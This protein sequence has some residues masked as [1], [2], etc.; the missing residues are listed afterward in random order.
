MSNRGSERGR[1]RGR[2]APGGGGRGGSRGGSPGGRGSPIARTESSA[3]G[4]TASDAGSDPGFSGRGRARGGP[5]FRGQPRGASPGGGPRGGEFDNR[6]GS[7]GGGPPRGGP[8]PVYAPGPARLDSRTTADSDALVQAFSRMNVG[9]EMPLRPGYGKLGREI[10]LRANFFALKIVNLPTIYDYDV[11]IEP[12]AQARTDRK[13]RIFDII[14]QHPLYVPFVTHVAHDRSQRLVSSKRLPQPFSVEVQYYEE[15]ED[16]PR[17]DALKFTVT[18]TLTGE[19]NMEPVKSYTSGEPASANY[20]MDP[21]VSALNLVLAQHASRNGV[22]VSKNK[23]FFPSSYERPHPLGIG[24]E[25][26]KGFF[27]SVRPT[28]KQL[29][30]NINV[31]MTAFYTAGNLAARMMEFNNRAGGMPSSFADRLRIATTHLGYRRKRAIFRI[32]QSNSRTTRFN[33]EEMNG[34]VSVED[35]FKRKYRINLR[36]PDLPVVN[37]GNAQRANYLPPEICEIID[38][39]AYR[40]KLDPNETSQ[41]IRVAA[42][43]PAA[44]EASIMTQGLP[45]LGLRPGTPGTPLA[46]FGLDVAQ[47][48]AVIPG[49][50]LPPPSITYKTGRPNVKEG[51][52]NILNVKFQSGG[53]MA[54]WAVMLVQEG[55]RNEF[56]GENDPQLVQF[57]QLFSQKC[58][59][60]GMSVPQVPPKIFA[61]PRL[62]R[63]RNAAL[64]TISH[65]LKGNL[66]NRRKPSFILVL[67]SGEDNFIYPGIK[68]M[69]DV[70][71][72]LHT[73]HM[74]LHKARGEPRKQDQYFS[75]VALKVNAKLGGVNHL[76]DQNSMKWLTEKSTML[77]GID[78][79]HPGPK[80]RP[81]TPSIAAVVASVDN[82]FVQFPASLMLQ[83]PDWN[84]EAKEVIPPPN[85]TTMML[86]RLKLYSQRNNSLPDR[87][88]VY[89]DGVSEGQY[90]TVLRFELPQILEAFKKIPR[91]TPYRPK[92]TIAICG[93]RHHVRL[94][95]TDD[96]D[97]T[98][99]GNTLPGTV[100]D[101]GITYVYHNDFYLQ[102]HAGLQG[103]VKST[104]YVIIYDENRYGADVLQQGTHTTSYLYARA[105]KAVSLIP[106][107]YYADLACERARYY[108]HNLLNL[109]DNSSGGRGTA[110]REAEKE[111]VYQEAVN[112][113]REGIHKDLKESMFYI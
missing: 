47:E 99:N 9:D 31:C 78:V 72:G 34:V 21:L 69:C 79:T 43:P 106:P 84:K 6:G 40:G 112:S 85:L 11:S 71:L 27:I 102:A 113:W 70:D 51:S 41:M 68:R 37:V 90:D 103:T 44:N 4:Y 2:G 104:H 35:Y 12:K 26:W 5:G 65:A 96:R 53:N 25:A 56:Q 17:S 98:R 110:D 45:A 111:R 22:R 57:L 64:E 74:L 61:T 66:D 95:A 77:V 55:R 63:D 49:R 8:P 100:V 46:G 7:R 97:K 36:Y 87:I 24:T 101:R 39:Q 89:R 19:L 94:Y 52:W 59:A 73:V 14:E 58:A 3:T 10:V 60:S 82:N 32:M 107:A 15:G 92:L 23:Y 108:L 1:P 54:N 16:G 105:T 50:V 13:R 48:M 93:K 30:V 18:I 20:N 88:F 76:L 86:E 28:A 81:G 29:M 80:S 109:S 62:P 33:C 75:N 83:K 91:K 38:G 42:N 67:L